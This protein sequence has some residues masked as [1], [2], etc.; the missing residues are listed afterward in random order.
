ML[1]T[2]CPHCS[3]TF[4]IRPE[5]L[6][7]RGGRV[8]CG[9][10]HTAF[11]ALESLEELPD[12][13]P[14]PPAG[15]PPQTTV[16]LQPAAPTAPA[17]PTKPVVEVAPAHH[18]PA[19]E[20]PATV[21]APSE[22]PAK[23]AKEIESSSADTTEQAAEAT[24][25]AATLPGGRKEPSLDPGW[26]MIDPDL[27]QGGF[28]QVVENSPLRNERSAPGLDL[29]TIDDAPPLIDPAKHGEHTLVRPR[30]KKEDDAA[31]FKME[32]DLSAV[33]EETPAPV[34]PKP[35]QPAEP[36][37][38]K[39]AA[40]LGLA[41]FDPSQDDNLGL[42]YM[43]DDSLDEPPRA[44]TKMATVDET[45]LLYL[46]EQQQQQ[47]KKRPP[48]EDRRR[49][50][51]IWPWA[52]GVILFAILAALQVIYLFRVEIAR[53]MPE[54]R[55]YMEQACREL[56]CTVPYPKD[57]AQISIEGSN[58]VAEPSPEGSSR[59]IVTLRNKAAHG[60]AWPH[61]ELTL[62]DKFDIAISR[63]V[64]KPSEWLPAPYAQ[65]AAFDGHSEVTANILLATGKPEP[66]GY[67]I[68]TFYP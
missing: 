13:Q 42:T 6:G 65:M 19:P 48:V 37:K 44:P 38:S 5:Q 4:R 26:L 56:G 33:Q 40:E 14:L 46:R 67:R 23:A 21:K 53:T 8:R 58:L 36:Y 22:E 64:L 41:P 27:P 29:P 12:D 18:A 47:L 17:V 63:R 2:R 35:S 55:P 60:V 31:A 52:L 11:S 24:A 61:L 50:R 43:L 25:P 1:T 49:K 3:T 68:Y 39:I 51:H 59:L 32:F 10:C 34:V 66:S 57:P 28:L 54:A 30:P 20:I 9:T 62:T 15:S 16:T 45:S 7:V